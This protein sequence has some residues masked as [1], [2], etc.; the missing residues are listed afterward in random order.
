MNGDNNLSGLDMLTVFSVILQVMGYQQNQE[1]T[2]N[3]ALLSELQRQDSEYLDKIISTQN[4]ILKLLSDIKS[5][6]ADKG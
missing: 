6:L 3:D 2:S 5:E 4:E 1:Q